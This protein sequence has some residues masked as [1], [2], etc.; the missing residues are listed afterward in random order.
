M[1]LKL[2]IWAALVAIYLSGC[3]SQDMSSTAPSSLY[4]RL[5]GKEA[6]TAV[7]DDVIVRIAADPRI[8][9][10]FEDTDIPELKT[11]LVDQLCE[12]SGGPCVYEGRDMLTAHVDMGVSQADFDAMVD[13]LVQSL[14]AFNVPAAEQQ[15]LLALLAPMQDDIVE[16]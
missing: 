2:S 13:D 7:V 10:F 11:Q 3:A 1:S 5:G 9:H 16:Q 4:Q 12:L 15:E 8:N 6:I 14:T